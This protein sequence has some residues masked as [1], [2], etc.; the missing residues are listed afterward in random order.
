M[1]HMAPSSA[2]FSPSVARQAASAA[3]DWNYVDSWLAGK[4]RGRPAPPFERNP[5]TLR[6]LLA[7]AALNETAD[8]DRD[9][10]ARVEAQALREVGPDAAA[11]AAARQDDDARDAVQDAV[12]GALPREGRQALD[13]L[14]A[15][16]TT[17]GLGGPAA[18]P[19]EVGRAMVAL[20]A[21]IFEAEQLAARV[22]VLRGH[23][24]VEAE[25]ARELLAEAEGAAFR[26]P[27][28][29]AKQNLEAQRQLKAGAARLPELQSRT[30]ALAA[31]VG[32]PNPTIE[33]VQKA[34]EEYLARPSGSTLARTRDDELTFGPGSAFREKR[35]RRADQVISRS[36]ARHRRSSPATRDHAKG[37]ASPIETAGCR[38]RGTSGARIASKEQA[39]MMMQCIYTISS[40]P[41]QVLR[42]RWCHRAQPI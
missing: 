33:D 1:A 4:F 23:V 35:A 5:D 40:T 19:A 6:A 15:A 41:N 42:A 11:A 30:A 13:A 38:F 12:E 10:L 39:M 2:I 26:P 37:S 32:V 8:E 18:T 34:E 20:Q 25:R 16:A 3:K 31:S 29:L 28:D 22:D 24:A 21:D 17:L 14:A 9:L 7:L 36:S 27:A